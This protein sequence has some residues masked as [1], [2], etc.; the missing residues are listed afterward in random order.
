ME[1]QVMNKKINVYFSVCTDESAENGEYAEHGTKI[2]NE[3]YSIREIIDLIKKDGFTELSTSYIP[4]D[5]KISHAWL[6]TLPETNY[7]NGNTTEH[8]LHI[9]RCTNHQFRRICK[10][11]GIKIN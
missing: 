11:A 5:N 7:I 6:S 10:T 4:D 2:E 8:T 9:S 3:E 1:D